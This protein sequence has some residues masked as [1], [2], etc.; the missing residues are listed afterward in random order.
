MIHCFVSSTEV[1]TINRTRP[2]RRWLTQIE[3][4]RSSQKSEEEDQGRDGGRSVHSVLP[5]SM[6]PAPVTPA[7]PGDRGWQ[8]CSSTLLLLLSLF[9][10]RTLT[11]EFDI[12]PTIPPT[13]LPSW[14]TV[15]RERKRT[16]R[17]PSIHHGS[18]ACAAP[19]CA[20]EIEEGGERFKS[21]LGQNGMRLKSKTE[22]SSSPRS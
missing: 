5:V 13:K 7:A 11:A 4:P 15:G 1:K 10:S 19:C 12:T 3:L 9:S 18:D 17:T 14:G 6:T 8:W 21:W 16:R 20:P 22:Y 2:L